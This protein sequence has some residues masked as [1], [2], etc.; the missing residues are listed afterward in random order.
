MASI[1]KVNT[2]QDATNSNTAMSIDSSG[3]V[4]TP[5]RPSFQYDITPYSGGTNYL[6]SSYKFGSQSSGND[7]VISY[8]SPIPF[9]NSISS[10][11]DGFTTNVGG[12]ASFA[13]HPAS[14][15]Y[16]YL[17][18]TAPI[19]G[20]YCFG[21]VVDFANRHSA[22]D[23]FGYGLKKNTA[24]QSASGSTSASSFDKPLIQARPNAERGNT[25][26]GTNIIDLAVN[27]FV[28]YYG[29]SVEETEFHTNTASFFGYLIG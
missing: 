5:A 10:N 29:R 4:L 12:G 25:T 3:R 15:S 17:K 1:L 2:I 21:M 23:Y 22:V 26:S 11:G 9:L 6:S 18:F 16:K 20:L 19:A 13:D 28:V 24:S 27:D 14:S 7:L 8:F